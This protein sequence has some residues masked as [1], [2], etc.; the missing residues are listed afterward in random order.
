MPSWPPSAERE[1]H[2]PGLTDEVEQPDV[3][4]AHEAHQE[5][6][7]RWHFNTQTGR[8]VSGLILFSFALT[9]FLNHALGLV[10]L[11]TMEA[12]QSIRRAFWR[13]SPGTILLYGAFA[14]HITLGLWRLVRRATWRMPMWEAIQIGLGLLI[15]VWLIQHVIATR[16]MHL[17]RGI[18]DTYTHELR[19]L[20]P[21]VAMSQSA[22]LLI[23]WVHA[24]IGLH[25]WLRIK[26]WYRP[27]AP[28]L[29]GLAIV[30]PVL[31]LAGWVEAARRVVEDAEPGTYPWSREDYFLA[32]GM[33]DKATTVLVTV[34]ILVGA[35]IVGSRFRVHLHKNVT[36]HYA[37]N[38]SVKVRPGPTLLE[39][40]RAHGIPHASI[41]GGRA[42]CTTCRVLITDGAYTLPEPNIAEGKAL[43]R[44]AAPSRVRLACQIRPSAD[45]IVRPLVPLSEAEETG[46]RHDP[47]RWG[48]E[49]RI[50]VMFCDLRSFTKLAERLYPYDS[51]FLLN[52][53]F[54]M[55]SNVIVRNGGR[56]DKF[57]GDGIM[58]L[59][60]VDDLRTAGSR[61][62]ILAARGMSDALADLNEEFRATLAEPLR[63]G[64]GI[65]T[66]SAILGRVGTPRS[67]GSEL[68]ALGDTVNTA[69]RLEGATKE[70]GVLCVISEAAL[71]ASGLAFPEAQTRDIVVRGR[72]EKTHIYLINEFSTL[73]ERV[74]RELTGA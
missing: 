49:R 61:D 37:N 44:I 17:A 15:P 46:P 27:L 2:D 64:I 52:R 9:H 63:I 19:I 40:S 35:A 54:E 51:V 36:I 59:F 11:E 13:S 53:Y 3:A 48:V 65:H 29:L 38:R 34:A 28:W 32:L 21:A 70:F 26:S 16:G 68:T 74:D 23:V 22:L 12:V 50:T 42:R 31:A 66:G 10:D 55:M 56:I 58:A 47:Y 7:Q 30:I 41:C 33:I 20:W 67:G 69:S 1:A 18:D 43:S 4:G 24:T 57:M 8:L 73:S 25:H 6:A 39:I 45:I 71:Q 14:V 5:P 62:A 60:G 72:E